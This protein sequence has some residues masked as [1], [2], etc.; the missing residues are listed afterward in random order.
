MLLVGLI[1]YAANGAEASSPPA[2]PAGQVP[3]WNN[4]G[5][6][7]VQTTT[8]LSGYG[9]PTQQK[10]FLPGGSI[11]GAPAMQDCNGI[12]IPIGLPCS[13]AKPS[14]VTMPVSTI[15]ST[16]SAPTQV[17]ANQQTAPS[18]TLSSLGILSVSSGSQTPSGPTVSAATP[19]GSTASTA[20]GPTTGSPG[21]TVTSSAPSVISPSTVADPTSALENLLGDWYSGWLQYL[22]GALN[23]SSD[24]QQSIS[25]TFLGFA[26]CQQGQQ[27]A[28]EAAIWQLMQQLVGTN[29]NGS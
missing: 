8:S 21:P 27:D 26:P 10:A 4:T 3:N 28:C 25:T 18:S 6:M 24:A 7:A 12:S 13:A 2:C 15:A 11:N 23:L 19:S 16:V 14:L 22:A 20:A 9:L 17:A 1:V 5:C 29:L